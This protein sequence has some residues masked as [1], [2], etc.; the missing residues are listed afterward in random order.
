MKAKVVSALL[1]G[2]QTRESA[3][4]D[5]LSSIV[6]RR[7]FA[8]LFRIAK[9]DNYA[10]MSDMGSERITVRIPQELGGR[11]RH[12]SRIKGQTESDLI[13]EALETYLG[14]SNGE[15]SAFELAEEAGLIG[16]VRRRGLKRPPK[17]LSTNP[18][19]FKGFGKDQ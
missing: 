19:H 10:I 17:D 14:R 9:S 3:L 15:R 4:R 11:L 16:A 7:G 18:R 8:N 2:M 1:V 12:R 6:L 13:R 5:G